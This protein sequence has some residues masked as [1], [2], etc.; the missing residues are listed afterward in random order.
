MDKTYVDKAVLEAILK[1]EQ[2]SVERAIAKPKKHAM[3][4]KMDKV[5][6]PHHFELHIYN[7]E[8]GVQD[9]LI[10]DYNTMSIWEFNEKYGDLWDITIKKDDITNK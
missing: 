6:K 9:K 1:V 4:K 5:D 7:M 2:T 10:N 8:R 3:E